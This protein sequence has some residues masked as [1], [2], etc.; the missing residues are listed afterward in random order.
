[1]NKILTLLKVELREA[2]SSNNSRKKK[3]T[4]GATMGLIGGLFVFLSIVY[5]FMFYM[6]FKEANSLNDFPI[7]M[8]ALVI[9]ITLVSSIFRSQMI[10]FSNKDHNILEPMPI[11]KRTIVA[12][13][14]IL[15]LIEEL[16][17]SIIIYLPT[18]VL[19]SIF[20]LSFI[21]SGII[22][23]VTLPLLTILI[24]VIV[25][26][27]FNLLVKRFKVAKIISMILYLLAF[28]GLM[29]FS[30]FMNG[31][32][33]ATGISSMADNFIKYI[34][35]LGLVKEGFLNGDILSIVIY[36]AITI[37]S[38]ALVILL[39]GYFY[40][41]FYEMLQISAKSEK[42]NQDK[43]VK[44][45]YP[46]LTLLNK[47]IRNLF[48]SPMLLLNSI[49]GGIIAIIVSIFTDSTLKE[50]TEPEA[51]P[52]IN[53]FYLLMPYLLGLLTTMS[54]ITSLSI[55]AENKSFWLSKVLPISKKIYFGS[56]LLANQLI[57]G[58]LTLIG[59]IILVCFHNY[60]I[61]SI[62]EIFI[63]PQLIIFA[64]GTFGLVI[65]LL[66][67]KLNWD[68]F[69]QIKN[70]SSVLITTFGGMLFNGAILVVSFF[71]INMY[72]GWLTRGINFFIPIALGTTCLILLKAKGKAW[73]NNIEV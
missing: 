56:K 68:N 25:G 35:F 4:F 14:L 8:G 15:F 28:V 45:S 7:F 30:L 46:L 32:S 59:S 27:V 67:P 55:S 9:N 53:V 13:K 50:I 60:D 40:N 49:V 42:F 36:L 64:Y 34:P 38:T 47:D 12:S 2:F 29:I 26:F 70:S 57:M 73:L 43:Q 63:Y 58:T 69:N 3:I 23:M 72:G 19:Y 5:N 33:T 71:T 20:N 39:Y 6:T 61:L 11:T 65:N 66:F 22:L 44:S 62:I 24:A 54:S 52:I 48:Q 37:G 21:V 31:N 17:Y 18:I 10:L 16:V 51:A 1:M 41:S